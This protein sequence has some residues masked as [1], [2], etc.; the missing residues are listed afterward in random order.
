MIERKEKEKK[1][2]R[3]KLLFLND[4]PFMHLCMNSFMYEFMYEFICYLGFALKCTR[5][6]KRGVGRGRKQI[7]EMVIIFGTE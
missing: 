2:G 7:G 6:I 3:R 5:K 1:K 4:E